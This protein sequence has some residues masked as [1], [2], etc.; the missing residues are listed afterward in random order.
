MGETD[1]STGTPAEPVNLV[2][3]AIDLTLGLVAL[4]ASALKAAPDLAARLPVRAAGAALV[5]TDR[6]QQELD[7]LL[8]RG[9]ELRGTLGGLLAG[10]LL[11]PP[12]V[13]DEPADVDPFDLIL[14][15]EPVEDDAAADPAPRT[16]LV[17]VTPAVA[18]VTP[19]ADGLPVEGFDELSLGAMRARA[20][21]LGIGELETLLDH[22]RTHGRRDG[23]LSLLET[24]I[25]QLQQ[26]QSAG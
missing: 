5:A 22:E 15:E 4:G 7:A 20:R 14:L 21:L 16:P 24:R 23:V 25:A 9:A 2:A 11:G 17:V 13:E 8:I 6:A 19:P 1:E 10:R 3:T 12:I 26:E 18:V